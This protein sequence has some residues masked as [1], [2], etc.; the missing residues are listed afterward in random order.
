MNWC[1]LLAIHLVFVLQPGVIYTALVD[2]IE[3]QLRSSKPLF[4]G[5]PA[6]KERRLKELEQQ[7]ATLLKEKVE[8]DSRTLLRLEEIKA[9]LPQ[10]Q[11]QLD[12][13]P[14]DEYCKQRLTL[15]NET[16]QT[17]KDL[18]HVHES[19]LSLISDYTKVI[20]GYVEDPTFQAWQK[21]KLPDKFYFQFEDLQKVYDA[22]VEQQKQI[23]QLVDQKRNSITE[24]ENSKRTLSTLDDEYKSKLDSLELTN[25][26]TQ[27]LFKDKKYESSHIADLVL[28]QQRVYEYKQEL[29][30][31]RLLVATMNEEFV[32][33]KLL[34][35]EGQLQVLKD[36][37][38]KVKH[39][40]RISTTDIDQAREEFNKQRRYYFLAKER[41]SKELEQINDIRK[42]K[43][44]ELDALSIQ[45]SMPLGSDL[46]DWNREP[47]QSASWYD[48]YCQLGL[49]NTQ[50]ITLRKSQE[51]IEAQIAAEDEKLKHSA[52]LVHAKET[53][54][55]ILFNKFLTDD[56]ITNEIK[57]YEASK[58]DARTFFSRYKE[59]VLLIPDQLN[60][61]KKTMENIQKLRQSLLKQKDTTFAT[62][63]NEYEHIVDNVLNVAQEKVHEY[64]DILSKLTGVYSE[65]SGNAVGMLHIIDFINGELRSITFW[66]R[67]DYAI[68]WHDVS[69]IAPDISAFFSYVRS[70]MTRMRLTSISTKLIGW[71][72]QPTDL[73]IFLIEFLLA[74]LMI[75]LLF[76]LV[77][78]IKNILAQ[79]IVLINDRKSSLTLHLLLIA[80]ISFV[81]AHQFGIGLW[82][83]IFGLLTF[84]GVAE[85]A[86]YIFF[87]LISIPYFLYIAY[88]FIRLFA[89]YNVENDY[90]FLA[91]DFQERFFLVFGTFLY[92]SVVIV[93]FRQAFI[94][95]NFH[96]SALP[97]ILLAI[98]FIIFQIALILLISKEQILHL[99]PSNGQFW[100]WIRE[101]IESYYYHVQFL[102][103]AIIIMINPYVGYGRLVLYSLIGFLYTTLLVVLLLWFY[104]FFKRLTSRAFFLTEDEIVRER[105]KNAKMWFGL[106][107][108][109]SFVLLLFI[110]IWAGAEIWGRPISYQEIYR[111]LTIPVTHSGSH[112]ISIMSLFALVGFVLGGILLSHAFNYY[113]LDKIFD[114][115]LVDSGVQHT[116]ISISG[117]VF[118][119]GAFFL[120]LHY[121]GLGDVVAWAFAALAL[122]LGWMLKDPIGDFIAYFV[123]LVQRP[124]KIGDYIRLDKDTM[125][126]V[127]RISVRS[128]MLRRRNS[129]TIIIPNSYVISHTVTNWNYLRGF[130]AFE[131]IIITI[132]YRED[133]VAVKEILFAAVESY[134]T[135][136]R[137]PRPI[138]RLETFGEYGFV[139]LIR[140]FISSSYTLDQWDIASDIRLAIALALRNNA[141]KIALPV[142]IT[143]S[144]DITVPLP[145]A[146]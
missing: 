5:L 118:F 143:A 7:Y 49:L 20:I 37:V 82:A 103:I 44:K 139:F 141:I 32:S 106:C 97:T 116:I 128:V 94:L 69:N 85:P 43:E 76:R 38:R 132:D 28:L 100:Q 39:S 2:I 45:Y 67:P 9:I 40:V 83:L 81:L 120:G 133:P 138:I 78:R 61:K 107:I 34:I 21:Q 98:H 41:D 144:R 122:S 95:V 53:Y 54:H 108:I 30:Q 17:V 27:Q 14:D 79:R 136:L 33:T 26:S 111:W 110:G 88:R 66:Y 31:L 63:Q 72:K 140:G 24:I 55:K 11:Q 13:S 6:E 137:T 114:L 68:S 29:S 124:I 89:Q 70:S 142:R 52:L 104:S 22:T 121:V 64:V 80:L 99:I 101:L 123:I 46:D 15:L 109:S 91:E 62:H 130:I 125:G 47:Q 19:Y 73:L 119:V 74:A 25:K 131:D 60:S 56:E 12:H 146:A 65:I 86:L 93:F 16:Y 1:Q 115:L 75:F 57:T 134:P 92:A 51:L 10:A 36:N 8:F 48:H 129:T 42:K 77:A 112:E 96:G 90:V 71:L 113:V 35:A 59:G 117:Y 135:I 84:H 145:P 102:I 4:T 50:V 58:A 18:R 3:Q 127:R 23:G 105:F 126:V 87:Y